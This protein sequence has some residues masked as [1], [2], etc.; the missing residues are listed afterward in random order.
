VRVRIKPIVG[1]RRL[2]PTRLQDNRA[3]EK[4]L[5]CGNLGNTYACFMVGR[6]EAQ[7]VDQFGVRT[8]NL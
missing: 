4:D 7:F 3:K 2:G 8:P 6:M 1:A 5:C